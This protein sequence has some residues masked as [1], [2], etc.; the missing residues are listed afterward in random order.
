MKI[1]NPNNTFLEKEYSRILEEKYHYVDGDDYVGFVTDYNVFR[2]AE[3][4]FVGLYGQKAEKY[5]NKIKDE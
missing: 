5:L 2:E 3:R 1:N 4:E